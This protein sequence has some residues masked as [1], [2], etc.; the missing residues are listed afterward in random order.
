MGIQQKQ[1][2]LWAKAVDLGSRV[3]EGHLLRQIDR[4]LDLSFIREKVAHLFGKNGNVSVDPVVIMR[5]MILLFVD[6]LRSER[7]L[8]RQIPLRIDYLWFLGY[9][10]D[11]EVP[12]HSVLSKAR[13]RWGKTIFDELFGRVVLQC[14]EAEL[15][16]SEKVHIDS[17]L[18]RA[19]ASLASVVK[20]LVGEE[21]E[22]LEELADKEE[23]PRPK[24]KPINT[25]YRSTTD[26]DSRVVRHDGGKAK[27]CFKNHRVVDD[28]AGVT[29]AVATTHG[30]ENDGNKLMDMLDQHEDRTGDKPGTAVADCCYGDTANFVELAQRGIQAHVGDLRS[31][32]RNKRAEG[33]FPADD[34]HYDSET[35][36]FEC[37]AGERLHRHHFMKSRGHW[38]YRTKRGTCN[39]CALKAQC[40]RAKTGRTLKRHEHQE[41]LDLA[42]RQSHS[43]EA[44]EDRK[45]R[46]WFQ[47][48]NF[49]EA[50]VMHGFKRARWRGLE[51]QSIQ[52]LLIATIQ[53]LKILVRRSLWAF[54]CLTK[55]SCLTW[56]GHG[57]INIATDEFHRENQPKTEKIPIALKPLTLLR[58]T[59]FRQ[60][61]DIS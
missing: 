40:T 9:G 31:R 2:E 24:H 54:F 7:E 41:E 15:V 26:P 52:D 37:P 38:E 59:L 30:V 46:Q 4:L 49:G 57:T 53:N 22:K 61:P 48:R 14:I 21:M 20:T 45:R 47:E 12:D 60:Q 8:M 23:A 25:R 32:L 27:P 58:F 13:K 36:T 43:E 5:M 18:I 39:D 10:L 44:R 1:G 11:D 19:D 56:K 55:P 29:T 28:K 51:K 16:G 50:A 42:R 6:N 3:P 17:S 34:F 35:D 33:I